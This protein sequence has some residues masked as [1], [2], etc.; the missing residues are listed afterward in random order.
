MLDN[1]PHHQS[2]LLPSAREALRNGLG[3]DTIYPTLPLPSSSPQPLITGL[4]QTH[5]A[6]GKKKVDWEDNAPWEGTLTSIEQ[7]RNLDEALEPSFGFQT[8]FKKGTCFFN[9]SDDGPSSAYFSTPGPMFPQDVTAGLATPSRTNLGENVREYRENQETNSFAV[10]ARVTNPTQTLTTAPT[11]NSL[12]KSSNLFASD[13]PN[14]PAYAPNRGGG[15]NP[16]RGGGGG[17]SRPGGGGDRPPNQGGGGGGNRGGGG[18]GGGGPP[19]HMP[20]VNN[21]PSGG[22]GGS[23]SPGGGGPPGGPPPPG[24]ES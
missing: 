23:G 22:G 3:W 15:N 8:P 19:F 9:T 4:P 2:Q 18:N 17:P 5:S 6:K 24:N 14:G 16:S 12:V 21:Y 10:T 7:A 11:S 20:H 13:S 1:V